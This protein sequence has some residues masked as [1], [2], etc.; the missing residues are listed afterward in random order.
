MVIF[1]FPQISPF[2]FVDAFNVPH[3]FET[4]IYPYL[5]LKGLFSYQTQ[6]ICVSMFFA[7]SLRIFGSILCSQVLYENTCKMAWFPRILDCIRFSIIYINAHRTSNCHS[8]TKAK[9]TGHSP[10]Q[11]CRYFLNV[12]TNQL[13]L[14]LL[15]YEF[16]IV[17]ATNFLPST[18]FMGNGTAFHLKC[19]HFGV[20]N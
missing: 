7:I 3:A 5:Y 10:N 16:H 14:L 1:R 13:L 20:S 4:D 6:S 9:K 19:A 17:I 15:L 8:F 12:S 11:M 2:R 18:I